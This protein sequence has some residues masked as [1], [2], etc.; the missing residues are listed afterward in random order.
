LGGALLGALAPTLG[1]CTT[2]IVNPIEPLR[3]QQV[4]EPKDVPQACRDHV[5]VFFIHGMDPLDVANL[6]AVNDYIRSLGFHRTYYGQLYHYWYF[7]DE[8]RRIHKEDPKARFALV[9]FSF[10]ANMV[11][12]IA[13]KVK[14]DGV[15]IDLLFYLGGNTLENKPSDRPEHV[16]HIVNI[17]ATGWIWHG[18]ELDGALNVNYDDV[19]H[20][21]SPAHPRT[22]R[23]LTK[24]LSEIA[25]RVPIEALV[26]DPPP[27]TG[28]IPHASAR[29]VSTQGSGAS[30]VSEEW[31]FLEPDTENKAA[32]PPGALPHLEA[33][34]SP[35]ATL[36]RR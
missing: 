31:R 2:A 12:D 10:G 26:P 27:P 20:F 34:D 13:N 8:V 14:D 15:P 23:M 3:A 22:V 6:G 36:G 9:G 1:G 19:W 33:L 24:E 21:G 30:Q 35:P 29:H 4:A 5:Y 17:L 32:P 7:T 25:R 11:R 16:A 18:A 28:P